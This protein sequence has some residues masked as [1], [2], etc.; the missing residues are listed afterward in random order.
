MNFTELL[1]DYNFYREYYTYGE[2][3]KE[4]AAKYFYSVSYMRKLITRARKVRA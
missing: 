2:T 1:E 3:I 4:L